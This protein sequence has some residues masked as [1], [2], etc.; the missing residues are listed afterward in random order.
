MERAFFQP[1]DLTAAFSILADHPDA[2]I[3][4]GGTD[5]VVRA[6]S[7][8]TDLPANLV[9]IDRLQELELIQASAGGG[10]EIGA[11]VTH[12]DIESSSAIRRWWSALSDAASLVGSPATR[13]LGT[14]GGIVCT[15]SPAMESGSPLLVFEATVELASG[16]GHRRLPFGAFVTG[17]GKTAREPDELLIAI[18]LPPLPASGTTGS[19]YVRLEY[20]QAMEIAIVGAA[21]QLT[22]DGDGR[23]TE[24]R[25]A[26]TAVGPTCVRAPGAEDTLVGR[27]LDAQTL[28]YAARAAEKHAKPIDDVR[29]PAAYR[30]AMVAVIVERALQT[31][32]NRARTA[33]K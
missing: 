24:A 16:R 10:L 22:I 31:A 26:L 8:R 14:I 20:R 5:L 9:A 32:W 17:P 28:G 13:H 27:I 4:A 1:A 30:Y 2:R 33:P 21:T 11:L 12:G 3:V 18:I 25:V 7:S 23:C 15:A 29:A 19:A 6:R